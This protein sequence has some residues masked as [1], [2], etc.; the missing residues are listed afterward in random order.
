[1]NPDYTMPDYSN[2][3]DPRSVIPTDPC[4]IGESG[5]G[6]DEGEVRVFLISG[7]LRSGKTSLSEMIGADVTFYHE[8]VAVTCGQVYHAALTARRT[9]TI[10]VE[11]V[12]PYEV[13]TYLR[14]LCENLDGVSFRHIS[15]HLW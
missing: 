11:A 4:D 1:M 2:A 14:D 6:P 15:I 5:W 12:D 9:T 8:N 3:P 13:T 7:P 10:V